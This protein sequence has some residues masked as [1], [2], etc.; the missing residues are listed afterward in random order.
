MLQH[1][2][3]FACVKL[4][5]TRKSLARVRKGERERGRESYSYWYLFSI[6]AMFQLKFVKH[7]FV[8]CLKCLM[9]F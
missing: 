3:C 4:A 8:N 7:N 5:E 2:T 6:Y 9:S 1:S